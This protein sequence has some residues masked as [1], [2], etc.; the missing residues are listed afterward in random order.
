MV[1]T[2]KKRSACRKEQAYTV[3]AIN[4]TRLHN[5]TRDIN[6]VL[7]HSTGVK[8][9][10]EG[11]LRFQLLAFHVTKT[12]KDSFSVWIVCRSDDGP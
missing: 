5:T 9:R 8:V 12:G 10:E 11:G 3:T 2:S 4:A 7:N 1:V 6:Q